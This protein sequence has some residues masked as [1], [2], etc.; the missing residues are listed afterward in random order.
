MLY[1][2]GAYLSRSLKAVPCLV[3][4]EH[5]LGSPQFGDGKFSIYFNILFK[6]T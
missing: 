3:A 4:T 6:I 5:S 2:Q 1:A